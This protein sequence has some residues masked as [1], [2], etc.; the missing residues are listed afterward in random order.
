MEKFDLICETL[1]ERVLDEEITESEAESVIEAAFDKYI[2][3]QEGVHSDAKDTF[4]KYNKEIR[5]C[6]SKAK[7]N[8]NKKDISAAKKNL[9]D[10]RKN[11]ESLINYMDKIEPT[12]GE[13][14]IGFIAENLIMSIKQFLAAIATLPIAGAGA[15]VLGLTQTINQIIVI[16]N[17]VKKDGT[18]TTKNFD[19][20]LNRLKSY[21]KKFDSQIKRLE[22]K[23]DTLK[24]DEDK[25][26]DKE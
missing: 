21:T 7:S 26:D 24:F 23:L 22:G 1:Y 19:L 17:D 12:V 6:L 15:F 13:A 25:K 3:C 5:D 9:S 16:V 10:A 8:I 20:Y 11:L 14:V 18:I 2:L 4:R